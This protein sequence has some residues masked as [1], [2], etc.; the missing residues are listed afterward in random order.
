MPSQATRISLIPAPQNDGGWRTDEDDVNMYALRR[1]DFDVRYADQ[2]TSEEFESTYRNV[3]PVLLRFRGGARDWTDPDVWT[4]DGLVSRHGDRP[5]QTGYSPETISNGGEGKDTETLDAYLKRYLDDE[6]GFDSKYVSDTTFMTELLPH[7]H[8]PSF[9]NQSRLEGPVSRLF[10]GRS[11]TGLSWHAHGQAWNGVVFGAKRWFL[12]APDQPPPGGNNFE[13]LDWMKY[14]QPY[15]SAV[16]RPLECLQQAGDVVY[17]PECFH[18]AVVNIGDT[19]AMSFTDEALGCKISKLGDLG[20]SFLQY[21]K[22]VG[23]GAVSEELDAE[24]EQTLVNLKSSLHQVGEISMAHALHAMYH[25]HRQRPRD[26]I[27][28][29]QTAIKTDPFRMKPYMMMASLYSSLGQDDKAEQAYLSALYLHETSHGVWAAY[30]GFLERRGNFT[31]AEK[32]YKKSLVARPRWPS[33]YQ[34]LGRV[35]A[36]LGKEDELQHTMDIYRYLKAT[37]TCT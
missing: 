18:H 32:A 26:A 7:V 25:D 27:S 11:G 2:L 9:L 14:V 3:R 16:W 12:S 33:L 36:R 4:R 30:G 34:R 5:V 15:V 23:G 35:Q 37:S 21:A 24:L 13:Q 19:V 1:C 10:L 20:R 31:A 28:L 29:F 8:L 17:I 6:Y 22:K